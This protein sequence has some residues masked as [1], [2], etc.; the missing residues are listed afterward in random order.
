MQ[1]RDDPEHD[2]IYALGLPRKKYLELLGLLFAIVCFS[3]M[4]SLFLFL[5]G[6][7]Y[8]V[9]LRLIFH[10]FTPLILPSQERANLYRASTLAH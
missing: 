7:M 4:A 9:V 5:F 2:V 6:M 1:A 8:N 10:L 3:S